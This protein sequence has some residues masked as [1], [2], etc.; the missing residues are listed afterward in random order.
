MFKKVIKIKDYGV[1]KDF[2]WPSDSSL[3]EFEKRNL[4]YGW[5]YSGKTTL[6][7]IFRAFEQ[8]KNHPDFSSSSFKVETKDDGS[9]T[10]MQLERLPFSVR[11]FNSDFI[12]ENLKWEDTLEPILILGE[13]NIELQKELNGIK[14]EIETKEKVNTELSDTIEELN[15]NLEDAKTEKARQIKRDLNI[16]ENYD[17]RNLQNEINI[18]PEKSDNLI[19]NRQEYQK[20]FDT[21]RSDDKLEVPAK[22]FLRTSLKPD[23]IISKI[24]TLLHRVPKT[25]VIEKLKNDKSLHDWVETGLELHK[26]KSTCEF[27]G[28]DINDERIEE[29]NNHYSSELKKLNS[30]LN[31]LKTKVESYKIDSQQFPSKTEFYAE[32]RDDFEK[33]KTSLKKQIKKINGFCDK[34]LKKIAEKKEDLLEAHQWQDTANNQIDIDTPV[35]GISNLIDKQKERTDE[36]EKNKKKAKK[37]LLQHFAAEFVKDVKPSEKLKEIEKK[38]NDKKKLINIIKELRIKASEIDQKL[39]DEVKGAERVNDYLKLYFGKSDI[40]I[41]VTPGK[42]YHLK[43]NDILAKNLSEGEKTAISFAYFIARLDDKHTELENT[44]VYLDDPISSLDSN[45]L[46][47]TFSIIKRLLKGCKQLFISTHNY[48]FFKILRDDSFFQEIKNKKKKSS[49]YQIKITRTSSATLVNLPQILKKYNSEYHYLFAMIYSF[50][51]S[52]DE[53]SELFYS[54]PNMLRKLLE[55]FTS[56]KVPQTSISLNERLDIVEPDGI[57]SG[58]IYK[59]VNHMSHSDSMSFTYEYPTSNECKDI[60]NLTM[61]M[62]EKCDPQHFEGMKKLA[63]TP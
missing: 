2:R 14:I 21:Y 18:L 56:F 42:K 29:L 34:I 41:E 38:E 32:L 31:S 62:I 26:N 11:V 60:I 9:F 25:E 52:G 22:I 10:H 7:R 44:V 5:N 19:L 3:D 51:E 61:K 49:L 45:H 54:L 50:A 40:K 1:F 58:R 59:F 15:E 55:I 4:I 57:K 53:E 39:S 13:E 48:E 24:Q 20:T 23:E 37:T 6:S 35:K 8:K 36:F 30:E 16:S 33:H 47:N 12:S 63:T 17:K 43:R 27:C 28:N 46:Y